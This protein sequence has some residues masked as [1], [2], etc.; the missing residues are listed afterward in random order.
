MAPSVSGEL[1]GVVG[2]VIAGSLSG[3]DGVTIRRL[4]ERDSIEAITEM[5]HRAYAPLAEAGMRYLASHQD[6]EMTLKRTF[7]HMTECWVAE[8]DGLLVG[9][10]TLRL[11]GTDECSYFNRPGVASFEQFAVDPH[12][13]GHGVGEALLDTIERR[14]ARHGAVELG[15]DTSEKADRLIAMYRRRGYEIVETA[16]WA[17]TNYA[18]VILSKRL[19]A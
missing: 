11:E 8:R 4:N 3:M 17:V 15:C 10:V 16:D 1:V 19:I 9:V 13:Q 6:D 7:G 5:L 14:A 18:S 2:V 12:E